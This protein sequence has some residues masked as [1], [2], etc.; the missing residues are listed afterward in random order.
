MRLHTAING[1]MAVLAIVLANT[2][3]R[4]PQVPATLPAGIRE[5]IAQ[6]RPAIGHPIRLRIPA[7]GIDAPIEPV[8]L[9]ADRSMDI[10]THAFS[11]GWYAEGTVPGETGNAVLAGHRDTQLGTPGIFWA[12]S[13]LKQNDELLVET[14]DGV[15]L[16]F[17]VRRLEEYPYDQAPMEKIFGPA[18]GNFLN[19]VTCAGD[20][21]RSTYEKRLV[22]FAERS[23][24]P[25]KSPP[26]D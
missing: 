7:R 18:E 1:M 21:N 17:L 6:V 26:I 19:L 3:L 15:H 25:S 12:L 24:D 16:R 23:N 20:W 22:V 5:S 11:V 8:G 2:V 10:P 13:T 4:E 14:F 9:T